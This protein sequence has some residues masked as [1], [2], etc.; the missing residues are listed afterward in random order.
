MKRSDMGTRAKFDKKV[1]I[2]L[3]L[4]SSFYKRLAKLEKMVEASTKA[5]LIRQALQLFEYVVKKS[6]AGFTFR[7]VDRAGKEETLVF[8]DIPESLVQV[9]QP[10]EDEK[11]EIAA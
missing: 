10:K 4:S 7:L 11:E 5:S 3:D 6:A 9:L 2:T 8:L 1:R